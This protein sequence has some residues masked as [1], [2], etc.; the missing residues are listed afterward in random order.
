MD[1]GPELQVEPVAEQLSQQLWREGGFSPALPSGAVAGAQ[2]RLG[3]QV[4]LCSRGLLTL[5]P[6]PVPPRASPCK[7]PGGG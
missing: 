2:L 1:Q 5:L 4:V 7:L 6:W 3:L